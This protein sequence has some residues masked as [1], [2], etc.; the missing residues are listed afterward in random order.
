VKNSSL[1]I[2]SEEVTEESAIRTRTSPEKAL[3][4]AT[5]KII[6]NHPIALPNLFET[7]REFILIS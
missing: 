6:E 4:T 3:R 1:R 5:L 2:L 7:G